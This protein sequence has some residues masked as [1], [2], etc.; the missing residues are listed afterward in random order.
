MPV[1][2][3]CRAKPELLMRSLMDRHDPMITPP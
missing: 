2:K 3:L 1:Y